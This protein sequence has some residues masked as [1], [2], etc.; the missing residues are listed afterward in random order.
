MRR[1]PFPLSFPQSDSPTAEG[2]KVA[3]DGGGAGNAAGT[4]S[5][6][7]GFA[8]ILEYSM[9]KAGGYLI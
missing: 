9:E 3:S 7:T 8:D 5:M 2:P 1:L 4:M 6:S